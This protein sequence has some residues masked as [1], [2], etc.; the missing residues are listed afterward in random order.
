MWLKNKKFFSGP[1]CDIYSCTLFFITYHMLDNKFKNKKLAVIIRFI[2]YL[3]LD[4]KIN[5]CMI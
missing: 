4:N 1:L 2:I 5:H 3:S